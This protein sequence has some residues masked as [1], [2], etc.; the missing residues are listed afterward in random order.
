MA[1]DH[2]GGS[3]TDFRRGEAYSGDLTWHLAQLKPGRIDRART[4]LWRQGYECLMPMQ[5]I[6]R[7]RRGQLV[8]AQRPLFPGYLFV[9]VP[10]RDANWRSINSTF[11]VAR[12][13]SFDG[14]SPAVVHRDLIAALQDRS[15]DGIASLGN[16]R[17]GDR[18]RVIAGPFADALARIES[19]PERDRIVVLVDM[20]GR[21]VRAAAGPDYFEHS[22]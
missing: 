3:E 13:V 22:P 5:A 14:F 6:T 10:E 20:M 11:G 12:L 8:S 2:A 16:F 1:Y 17:L 7:R 18:V 19:L 4:N 9:G 15:V 21:K